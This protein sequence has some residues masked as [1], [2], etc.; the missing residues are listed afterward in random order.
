MNSQPGYLV[1]SS[2]LK[3]RLPYSRLPPDHARCSAFEAEGFVVISSRRL[4]CLN[5]KLGACDRGAQLLN[6]RQL[7]AVFQ[8]LFILLKLFF[9][10]FKGSLCR[11]IFSGVSSI[12]IRLPGAAAEER[13]LSPTRSVPEK[14]Q[15]SL[16]DF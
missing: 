1:L 6:D 7:Q 13:Q 5:H 16:F 9:P 4:S 2:A 11:L 15:K 14:R 10:D 12:E 8:L 3:S